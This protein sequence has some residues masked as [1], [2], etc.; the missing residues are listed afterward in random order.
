MQDDPGASN[1]EPHIRAAIRPE[2]ESERLLRALLDR[3]WPG[4][5]R[6]RLE[7]LARGWLVAWGPARTTIELPAC[8]CR[9]GAC[10]VCN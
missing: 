10:I 5:T 9:S 4:G 7:P 2:S 8:G 6:D 3:S 1:L